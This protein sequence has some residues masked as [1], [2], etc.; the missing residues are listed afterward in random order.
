MANQ[1]ILVV[2]DDKDIRNLIEIY[3]ENEGYGVIKAEDGKK[4]MEIL[5][6]IK[7]DLIILDVM[8]PGLNGIEFC[9]NVRS[10][11]HMPIIMLSAKIQ[12][13]DKITG[14]TSGADDYLT[15]PFNPLE[16]IAR[17]KSQ[18]RRYLKWHLPQ[19]EQDPDEV[20]IKNLVLNNATHEVKVGGCK[21]NL[22]PT[23]FAILELLVRNK[24]IVFSIEKI[25]EKVWEDS[26]Y[27]TDNTV[28]VHIQ[29]IRKKIETNPRKPEF[30]K[31]VWGV[32][33]K[34]EN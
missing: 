28:V 9:I 26:F 7:V 15:K 34:V 3:L 6:D 23:E 29:K 5:H 31:T 32:G 4:A 17:I 18:L 10:Y 30:I 24:G 16:L 13:I 21:V 11:H 27:E 2:D 25:Y 14:L 1:T 12:D 19:S 22:T 8:M 33:Y 20:F